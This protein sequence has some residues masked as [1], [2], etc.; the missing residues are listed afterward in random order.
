MSKGS[1]SM[2]GTGALSEGQAPTAVVLEIAVGRLVDVAC[3][4]GRSG[5]SPTADGGESEPDFYVRLAQEAL[6]TYTGVLP[7]SG[8]GSELERNIRL[9]G[10]IFSRNTNPSR[11]TFFEYAEGKSG[12]SY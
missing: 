5:R 4:R 3:E 1:A 2:D 12:R 6:L 7:V 10:D 9:M 11:F 8:A